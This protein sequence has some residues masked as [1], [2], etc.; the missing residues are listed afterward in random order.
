MI[1]AV[2]VIPRM[3]GM[4]ATRRGPLYRGGTELAIKR[5]H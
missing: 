5:W 3:A 4:M 2:L 1:V